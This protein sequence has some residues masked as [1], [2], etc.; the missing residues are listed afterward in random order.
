M[1]GD[2]RRHPGPVDILVNNAGIFEPVDFFDTDDE[3]WDRHWK[4]NVMSAV[5]LSRSYAPAMV[6]MG[7]G[8]EDEQLRERHSPSDFEGKKVTP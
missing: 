8:E 5:R 3:T 4:V 7:W 1:Q 6:D 2:P